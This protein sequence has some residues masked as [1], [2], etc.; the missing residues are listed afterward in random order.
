MIGAFGVGGVLL[1]PVLTYALGYDLQV[2]QAAASFSFLFTGL[3]G[4]SSY[5]REGSIDWR[6]VRWVSVGLIPGAVLG[7]LANSLVPTEL[8]AAALAVVLLFAGRRAFARRPARR[9]VQLGVPLACTAACGVGIGSRIRVGI[10]WHRRPGDP[11]PNAH[12]VGSGTPQGCRCQSGIAD[13]DRSVR[14]R[15]FLDI[16]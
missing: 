13:P 8:L 4:T 14:H 11:R 5:A 10:D 16:R 7:A 6:L 12:L 2:A 15:K 9:G 3:V 1:A